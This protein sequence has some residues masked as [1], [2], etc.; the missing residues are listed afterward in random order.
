MKK[1]VAVSVAILLAMTGC[2]GVSTKTERQARKDLGAVG[3]EFRPDDERPTLPELKPDSGLSNFLA[4]AML[5]QPRVEAAYYDWARSVERITVERSLPDPQLT[6]QSD[7]ANIVMT[8]MPGFLQQFPGPGK[9]KAAANVAATGS[10][11]KYFAFESS[12]LQT[13]LD[14]K[15]SYYSLHFLDEKL[16]INRK[17]LALLGDLDKIAQAQ[18][19]VGKAT[20]QDVYRA[21]IEQNQLTTAIANLEDSRK[22]LLAQFKAAL[23]LT[24]DQP[25]PPVSAALETTDL[26]LDADELLAAAFA[27]NPRLKAMEADVRM[28]EADVSLAAKA[29]VPDFSLGLMADAKASPVVYR[30]LAGM[31]LPIWRDKIAAQIAA[32]QDAKRAAGARLTSEQIM[33]TVDFAMKTYDYREVTRN[34]ALLQNQLIPKARQ[35]ME[36]ARSGYLAGNI[37]F[38]NLIDAQRTLLNFELAEVEARTRREIVLA[39]LSLMI[40]GVPPDGAPVLPASNSASERMKS[41]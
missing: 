10:Q 24:H 15:R 13:A 21:Q 30:P 14:L 19:E 12:V 6:F 28:A 37:D 11:A 22:P 7:I 39:E 32:A 33:L 18:N 17:T 34:L 16:R 26:G 40:V 27:R 38:F 2:I 1:N 25:D 20:L 35:S 4:Y 31:T 41:K 36:I 9:L 29:K 8:V 23:G 3:Q 5:N